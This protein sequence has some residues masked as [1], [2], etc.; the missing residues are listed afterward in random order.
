LISEPCFLLQS[1]FLLCY[2]FL[3]ETHSL[4]A[5]ARCCPRSFTF[6]VAPPTRSILPSAFLLLTFPATGKIQKCILRAQRPAIAP[7]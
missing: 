5:L 2:D 4:P 6:Y 7:R 3:I 1:Y